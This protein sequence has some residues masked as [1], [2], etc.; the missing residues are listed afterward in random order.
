[1]GQVT[2]LYGVFVGNSPSPVQMKNATPQQVLMRILLNRQFCD[3]LKNGIVNPRPNSNPPVYL[4]WL[5]A[6]TEEEIEEL[7]NYYKVKINEQVEI[8]RA[9]SN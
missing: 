2:I 6:E 3:R 9:S 7:F 1:M 4:N 8:R 5:I